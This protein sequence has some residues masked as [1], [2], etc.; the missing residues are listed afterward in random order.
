M[1]EMWLYRQIM[2]MEE[3]RDSTH[4]T[5][6]Y[7]Y[8]TPAHPEVIAALGRAVY[9]FLSLEETVSAILYEAQG[10]PLPETR[11]KMAKRKED[12]LRSLAK[13][14]AATPAGVEV[15]E[16]LRKAAKALEEAREVVRNRVLHAH[17]YTAGE[18]ADGEYLPGLAYTAQDGKSWQ[19]IAQTPSDLLDLAARVEEAI[20]P[21]ANAR[22]AV[23]EFPLCRM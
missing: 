22:Q 17:P 19:Y 8:R 7:R 6:G 15:A 5:L 16:L 3:S 13:K 9:N 18:D 10:T 21:L 1:L 2:N 14:Y 12:G 4:E 20:D 11:S 23:K